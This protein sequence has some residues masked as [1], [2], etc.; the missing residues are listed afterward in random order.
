M[1]K[2]LSSLVLLLLI[3]YTSF[4]QKAANYQQL[5]NEA[6]RLHE[7]KDFLK[8]AQIYSKALEG[9]NE[10]G[11]TSDRFNAACSWASAKKPDSAFIQLFIIAQKG[12]F[13]DLMITSTNADLKSLHMDKRWHKVLDIV[14][15]NNYKSESN[16]DFALVAK[17]DTLNEEYLDSR[18]QIATLE[19]E[20]GAESKEVKKYVKLFN[21]KEASN[22]ITITKILDKNGWPSDEIV[23]D[24]GNYNLYLLLER[25]DLK[26]QQKYLPMMRVAASKGNVR[27]GYLAFFEDRVAMKKNGKQVYGSQVEFNDE[28]QKYYVLPLTDP[29]NVDKRRA[30]LGLNSMQWY[31]TY[32]SLTWDAEDYK[33]QLPEYIKM[34]KK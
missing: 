14:A 8:S 28:M 30:E 31:I 17:L 32:W 6:W 12:N 23:G 33:K 21:A 25:A 29:D 22:L 16:I 26:V 9:M 15:A 10:K 5:I 2:L 24:Q 11:L 20:F 3:C 4:A 7:E 18:T 34:Y 1:Q 19:S 27:P 13:K